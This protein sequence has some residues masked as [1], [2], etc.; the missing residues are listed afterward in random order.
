MSV[1]EKGDIRVGDTIRIIREVKVK[2]I[3][4]HGIS[5]VDGGL[6]SADKATIELVS[7]PLPPLPEFYG[8]VIKLTDPE[9]G[10]TANWLLHNNDE[11]VS[12]SGARKTGGDMVRFMTQR[13][14]TFEV[15]A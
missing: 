4:G 8:S 10:S 2:A 13:G 14:L 3:Y 7:R 5:T 12:A 15:I 9:T 1:I 11:W 6:Y